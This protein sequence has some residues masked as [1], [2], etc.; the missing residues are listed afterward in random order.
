MHE[1]NSLDPGAWNSYSVFLKTNVVQRC[2]SLK[3]TVFLQKRERN[4]K[5]SFHSK[6]QTSHGEDEISKDKERERKT[7]SFLISN[8]GISRILSHLNYRERAYFFLQVSGS[9]EKNLCYEWIYDYKWLHQFVVKECVQVNLSIYIHLREER[10]SFFNDKE[11]GSFSLEFCL[12][13]MISFL[14]KNK[15]YSTPFTKTP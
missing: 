15:Y 8:K 1:E 11:V 6:W 9:Q 2:Y 13:T 5:P 4:Q 3:Q 14:I 10:W 12:L 7:H